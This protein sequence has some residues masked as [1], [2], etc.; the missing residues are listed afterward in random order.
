ME[1]V[2]FTGRRGRAFGQVA[3]HSATLSTIRVVKFYCQLVCF[4][5][6]ALRRDKLDQ[7]LKVKSRKEKVLPQKEDQVF[8][9]LSPFLMCEG[10]GASRMVRWVKHPSDTAQGVVRAKGKGKEGRGQ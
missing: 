3:L 2:V 6:I 8:G 1:G 10:P 5:G 4:S 9:P 7:N